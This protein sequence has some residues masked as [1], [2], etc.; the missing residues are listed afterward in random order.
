[1][2]RLGYKLIFLLMGFALAWGIIRCEE[3]RAD[4]WIR[5]GTWEPGDYIACA[6]LSDGRPF[7]VNAIAEGTV[8]EAE[9]ACSI[10]NDEPLTVPDD[11]PIWFKWT[12]KTFVSAPMPCRY[13]P[14]DMM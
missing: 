10:L 12:G 1:M 5:N 8:A 13:I 11:V 2:K 14:G 9:D 6:I 3:A 4:Q 7:C